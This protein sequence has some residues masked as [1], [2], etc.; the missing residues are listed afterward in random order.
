MFDVNSYASPAIL[1]NEKGIIVAK[2][3]A[4]G[5]RCAPFRKGSSIRRYLNKSDCNAVKALKNGEFTIITLNGIGF[6]PAIVFFDG[7]SYLIRIN[8]M[9]VALSKRLEA[10]CNL[11]QK[12]LMSLSVLANPLIYENPQKDARLRHLLYMQQRI[13]EY[14]S[15]VIGSS[16]VTGQVCNINRMLRE[17]CDGAKNVLRPIN[18]D[19]LFL[20]SPKRLAAY[21]AKRDLEYIFF[22]CITLCFFL[23]RGRRIDAKITSIGNK[24]IISFCFDDFKSPVLIKIL[25]KCI[26]ESD[27][28]GVKGEAAFILMY[29]KTL[30]ELYNGKLTLSKLPS[31]T[32]ALITVT[33]KAIDEEDEM[34]FE[35]PCIEEDYTG[36]AQ[37]ALAW[38]V[39]MLGL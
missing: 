9:A 17:I 30:C 15:L 8:C 29:A 12:N 3:K 18:A 36:K 19:V 28:E 27:F 35:S 21:A 7:D 10:L 6:I 32:K 23:S 1:L 16:P 38:V 26:E 2:N 25:E 34:V 20:D 24:A 22:A 37:N 5:V 14:I 11:Q 39:F 4:A 31:G 13:S 33:L